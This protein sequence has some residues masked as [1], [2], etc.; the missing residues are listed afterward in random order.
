MLKY[1]RY[2]LKTFMSS[3]SSL[4]FWEDERYFQPY[5]KYYFSVPL[6][7]ERVLSEKEFFSRS[8]YLD[9]ETQTSEE[10]LNITSK[11][12]QEIWDILWLNSKINNWKYDIISFL[13]WSFDTQEILLKITNSLKDKNLEVIIWELF[14]WLN[15]YKVQNSI[16]ELISKTYW[17]WKMNFDEDQINNLFD[18]VNIEAGNISYFITLLEFYRYDIFRNKVVVLIYDLFLLDHNN[19]DI[20]FTELTFNF[21]NLW[22]LKY[23][24]LFYKVLHSLLRY[25]YAG[26]DEL[27]NIVYKYIEL[28]EKENENSLIF[29]YLKE[30][31]NN[32]PLKWKISQLI[33]E[34]EKGLQIRY[35]SQ[36]KET[37]VDIETIIDPVSWLRVIKDLLKY[38]EETFPDNSLS[39]N[40]SMYSISQDIIVWSEFWDSFNSRYYWDPSFYYKKDEYE[41]NRL[42]RYNYNGI[43]EWYDDLNDE[44]SDDIIDY[45]FLIQLLHNPHF[46]FSIEQDFWF[47]FKDY[48]FSIQ[49]RFMKFLSEANVGEYPRIKS[50]FDSWETKE[51]KFD[52]LNSFIGTYNNK[53]FSDII[54]KLWESDL[55]DEDVKN[56][57]FN[58]YSNLLLEISESIETS[59]DLMASERVKIF[60]NMIYS[61]N[62]IFKEINEILSKL[63]KNL[64][65]EISDLLDKKKYSFI[66]SWIFFKALEK[67][68]IKEI[69]DLKGI[70]WITYKRINSNNLDEID[71]DNIIRDFRILYE[72]SYD[73]ITQWEFIEEMIWWIKEIFTKW[74]DTDFY[75]FYVSWKPVLSSYFKKID[76]EKYFWW[77]NWS[78]LFS[79]Y[80]FWFTVLNMILKEQWTNYSINALILQ[81][82][83]NWDSIIYNIMKDKLKDKYEEI[84]F[85]VSEEKIKIWSSEYL[86]IKK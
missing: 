22:W 15:D 2:I 66:K 39:D 3:T 29:D 11:Y 41:N 55:L 4:T 16:L 10:M 27:W 70:P 34:N 82:T 6:N 21:I 30:S 72:E 38:S 8:Y 54:L 74:I 33:R 83:D 60:D 78:G 52:R 40:Y 45:T 58:K 63:G 13:N 42:K 84:W 5:W 17:K 26:N 75:L 71:K 9:N 7:W 48:P 36:F 43:F 47:K 24:I 37:K 49:P 65:L 31:F 46:L 67:E 18:D 61:L 28:F 80:G 77:F 19:L 81:N 32:I 44:N 20:D 59:N 25:S 51:Q 68:K 62:N 69:D 76:W 73:I 85:I 1:I 35:W 12:S 79:S 64:I 23:K 53:E 56:I 14:Y 50:L 86:K 57:I